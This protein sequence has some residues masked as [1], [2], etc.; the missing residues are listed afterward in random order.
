MSQLIN[1]LA[2]IEVSNDAL[3]QLEVGNIYQDFSRNYRKL[4]DLKNFRSEYENKNRVMRWWHNDK[5]RDAQLD[6]AEVQAEFSKTIGQLMMISIMQSKK[7]A[8][9]QSQLNSQQG[10][11]KKQADGIA[12]HAGTLQQQHEVL[13]KQSEKLESLVKEYFDLKGLTED[14]AQKLIEIAKEVRATKDGMLQQFAA[15]AQDLEALHSDAVSRMAS[16][17]AEV[18]GR[19]VGIEKQIRSELAAL[20]E[21]TRQKLL[22]SE[23]ALRNEHEAAQ[24]AVHQALSTL[25]QDLQASV[26]NQLE[27]EQAYKQKIESIE[28]G[29][30]TQASRMSDMANELTSLKT[31]LAAYAQRQSADQEKVA[32]LQQEFSDRLRK[33]SLGAAGAAVLALMGAIA[34]LLKWI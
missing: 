6:S 34:H 31:E 1:E 13:A 2:R 7:L 23:S 30:D 15:R 27:Q 10:D 21:E 22:A 32:T 14:G 25:R 16:L 29:L 33:L 28:G 26:A 3:Q 12:E 18:D 17:S 19:V 24:T 5:L 20:D 9:Q 8:E 4:D 11:L